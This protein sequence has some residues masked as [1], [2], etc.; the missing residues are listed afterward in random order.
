MM[1][2]YD[3]NSGN[4]SMSSLTSAEEKKSILYFL[5]CLNLSL[6]LGYYIL[7]CIATITTITI[8]ITTYYLFYY[9]CVSNIFY[10]TIYYDMHH[11]IL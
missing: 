6:T 3:S 5:I 11:V 8:T 4:S 9:K 1:Y 7:H 2:I 10:R